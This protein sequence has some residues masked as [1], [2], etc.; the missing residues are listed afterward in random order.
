MKRKV[1]LILLCSLLLCTS[2]VFSQNTYNISGYISDES[3]GEILIGAYIYSGN[4]SSVTNAYGFYSLSLPTGDTALIHVSAIGYENA[5]HRVFLT[6]DHNIDFKLNANTSI[7]EVVINAE[8]NEKITTVTDIVQIS[9]KDIKLLP[10]LAGEADVLRAFQLMP[11]IQSGSEGTSGLY[12]RGGSPD[13]NLILLDGVPLYYVNHIGGFVS[14]FDVNAIKDVKLI[15][16]AFPAE[17]GGRLSSVLDVRLKDGNMKEFH[18]NFT[19]GLLSTKVSLESPIKKDTSSFIISARRCN[20]DLITRPLSWLDLDLSGNAGYTFWD[21]N[22]KANRKFGSKDRIFLSIYYGRDRVFV[23]GKEEGIDED[24]IPYKYKYDFN[25]KWGNLPIN[26]RWNHIFNSKLFNNFNVS[27]SRFFYNTH[28][29]GVKENS[30][31]S[32]TLYETSSSFNS[33]ITDI[34]LKDDF[35]WSPVKNHSFQIGAAGIYHIFNPGISVYVNTNN[36]YPDSTQKV[37]AVES[38]AYIKD[39]FKIGTG[40][41]ADIGMHFSTYSLPGTKTFYSFQPRIGLNVRISP[42]TAIKSSYVRMQQNLH[43]LSSSNVGFPTDL[44]V[45][46]TIK[47]PPEISEQVSC[48]LIQ[49]VAKSYIISIEAYYKEM[50]KLIDFKEG[51]SFYSGKGSWEEKI[52]TDGKGISYGTEVLIKKE[53][54]RLNGWISY[55]VSKK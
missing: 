52:E 8:R 4:Y 18:G 46:A 3:T 41:H 38:Y 48:G 23:N 5:F 36:L 50:N 14:V 10:A 45:P 2:L 27:F 17:Y 51:S 53:A 28:I 13:Q 15:K 49:S 20:V 6:G 26:F 29:Q 33:G 34:L 55:T 32:Q 44:W 21:I 22:A 25:V 31:S 39:N 43:L 35:Q 7:E 1:Q 30:N 47:A 9:V 42:T 37:Y 16:G 54:G 11:G 24:S 40:F 12:V 19:L